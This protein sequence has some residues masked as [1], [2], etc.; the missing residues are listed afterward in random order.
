LLFDNVS[1]SYLDI[2]DLIPRFPLEDCVLGVN[3]LISLSV[4]QAFVHW[5]LPPIKG[6]ALVSFFYL[7]MGRIDETL[8]YIGHLQ[9]LRVC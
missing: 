8:C 5:D 4:A 6:L 9:I 7:F 3:D 1:W 2:V